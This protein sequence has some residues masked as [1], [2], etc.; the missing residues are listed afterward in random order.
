[1]RD[2]RIWKTCR[3]SRPMPSSTKIFP[4]F[5]SDTRIHSSDSSTSR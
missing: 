4:V 3:E 5:R 1:M 2:Q